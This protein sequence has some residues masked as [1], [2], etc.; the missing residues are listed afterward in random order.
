MAIGN[1]H[2]ERRRDHDLASSINIFSF[3]VAGLI[4][5]HMDPALFALR[6]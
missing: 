3:D 4:Q 6:K 5:T 2:I 1:K